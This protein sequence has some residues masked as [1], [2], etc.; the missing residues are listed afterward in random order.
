MNGSQK[1]DP[2]WGGFSLHMG[3]RER[4]VEEKGNLEENKE[5]AL[6]YCEVSEKTH[7]ASNNESIISEKR[8]IPFYTQT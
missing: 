8:V 2:N 6:D 3:G 7:E 4:R 1:S 5:S